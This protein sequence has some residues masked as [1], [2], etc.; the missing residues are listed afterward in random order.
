MKK[1]SMIKALEMGN[2][3]THGQTWQDPV[4]GWYRKYMDGVT[5][6]Q[7]ANIAS[8]EDERGVNSPRSIPMAGHGPTH[9]DVNFSI[10]AHGH[11]KRYTK[12][13][14]FLTEMS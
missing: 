4:C 11:F 8:E 7:Y 13:S 5:G 2:Y 14:S 1:F 6:I 12:V 9:L 10:R 3:G